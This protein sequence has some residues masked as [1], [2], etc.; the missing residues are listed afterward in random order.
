MLRPTARSVGFT[1]SGSR[2]LLTIAGSQSS[3]SSALVRLRL[4]LNLP[5]GRPLLALCGKSGLLLITFV[6]FANNL[7]NVV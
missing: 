3:S 7:L 4:V 5:L 6:F 1:D 2:D